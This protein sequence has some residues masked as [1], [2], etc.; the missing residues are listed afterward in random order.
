MRAVRKLAREPGFA[1]VDVPVPTPGPDEVLVQVKAASICGTDLHI[2]DWDHWAAGHVVTPLTVGHEFCG[3]VV[4]QGERV[5]EPAVG[6]LVSAESH[7]VCGRCRFCL[8]AKGHLCPKTEILGVH[9]DGAYA[10]YI[11]VPAVNAWPDPPDMPYSIASL[12]ENFGNA[13]HAASVF[14]LAGRKV[15][16]TGM[17]PVG[18]MALATARAL[19]ARA[20]YATDVSD[21]RLDLA[22][23]MGADLTLNPERDDLEQ[24]ILAATDGEGVDAILEMSGA[25]A[26]V[27]AAFRVL[28]PGG[29]AAL[30][31]LTSRPIDFDLDDHVIFK[32]ASVHGV[33]GRRLWDTWY[34][35]RGLLR[36]G[37]VDLAPLVTHRFALDDVDKAFDLMASG[38]CGK[39]ILF[40]D[41]ADADGPLM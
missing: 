33:V 1:L 38:Q 34:E 37:A 26:A 2:R 40:P 22:R 21:Y 18:I 6:Q 10:E 35:M 36:A 4:E 9:R 14:R 28:K 31:G 29:E 13:V 30:L 24:M 41:P 17:G 5:T 8:T 7:V 27:E 19:G 15:L 39:V 16:V 25:P 12:Q 32:G 20:V 3:V 23:T 11:V